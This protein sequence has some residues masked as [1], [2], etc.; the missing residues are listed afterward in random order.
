MPWE[1]TEGLTTLRWWPESLFPEFREMHHFCPANRSMQLVLKGR[2]SPPFFL[3]WRVWFDPKP[4]WEQKNWWNSDQNPHFYTHATFLAG[5]CAALTH[6]LD[7]KLIKYYAELL[8]LCRNQ[9]VTLDVQFRKGAL[10]SPFWVGLGWADYRPNKTDLWLY[11]VAI[12]HSSHAWRS[13]RTYIRS[14]F[15]C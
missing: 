9:W 12:I 14:F 1:H 15:T 2:F 13:G 4:R 6:T 11:R 3:L 10:I 5:K 7:P 8:H